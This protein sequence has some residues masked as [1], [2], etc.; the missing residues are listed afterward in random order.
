MT[1][2]K[3]GILFP[4]LEDSKCPCILYT[5]WREINYF[6]PFYL[7]TER[8]FIVRDFFPLLFLI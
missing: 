2:Q 7:I 1:K 3:V 8:V 5:E 6:T 4:Y